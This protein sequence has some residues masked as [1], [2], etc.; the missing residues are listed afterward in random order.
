MTH[1]MAFKPAHPP[2][3]G[4]NRTIGKFPPY[5]EDPLR[6]VERKKEV[7]ED[8]AKWRSTHKKRT[9]PC[10]SVVTNYRNMKSE[11]PSVFRRL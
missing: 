9:V 11:F 10:P 1:D 3:T 7:E 2:R 8:K 4:Y 5:V 6:V